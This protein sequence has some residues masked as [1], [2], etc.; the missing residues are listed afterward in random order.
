MNSALAKNITQQ[1]NSS[2]VGEGYPDQESQGSESRQNYT[3]MVEEFRQKEEEWK[4]RIRQLEEQIAKAND[5][6]KES[7]IESSLAMIE[8]PAEYTH[9]NEH[10]KKQLAMLDLKI[11]LLKDRIKQAQQKQIRKFER[12]PLS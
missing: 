10:E 1:L 4:N 11:S 9:L 2:L 8:K 5:N 6:L 12:G 7:Q 3:K